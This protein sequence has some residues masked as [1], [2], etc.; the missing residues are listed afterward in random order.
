M[1]FH[2]VYDP[3]H[4]GGSDGGREGASGQREMF[5]LDRGVE[6]PTD[7]QWFYDVTGGDA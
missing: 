4:T 6:D 3:T 5:G 2:G 7:E 1:Q